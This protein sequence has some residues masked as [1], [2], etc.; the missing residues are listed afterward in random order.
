[1][2]DTLQETCLQPSELSLNS[3]LDML[4]T[5]LEKRFIKKSY[6]TE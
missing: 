6:G 2:Q 3:D 5:P 4:V 1:M